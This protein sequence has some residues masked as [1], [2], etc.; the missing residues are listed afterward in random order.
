MTSFWFALLI[1]FAGG[2]ALGLQ[3]PLNSALSGETGDSV[4]ATMISFGVGFTA[5]ALLTLFRGS[6]PGIGVL[7][8]TPPWLFAG[9][10]LG[11]FYV[12]SALSGVSRLGVVTMT[13]VL[14][15]GQMLVAVVIDKTG[16]FGVPVREISW[17]RVTAILLVGAGLVMSRL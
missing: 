12:W 16:A 8:S 9:G 3:A 7:R 17:Q 10:L 13:A 2:I 6:F 5:L 4:S 14:I 15:L 11:A 1:V